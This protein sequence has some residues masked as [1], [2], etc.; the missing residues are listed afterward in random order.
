MKKINIA[1]TSANRNSSGSTVIGFGVKTIFEDGRLA[2][3][4]TTHG[5]TSQFYTTEGEAAVYG[6]KKENFTKR[7]S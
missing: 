7:F 6:W 5:E 3:I 4:E 1:F 2:Q